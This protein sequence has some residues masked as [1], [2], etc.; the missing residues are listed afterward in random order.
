MQHGRQQRVLPGITSLAFIPAGN[1]KYAKY[2][3]S[4]S[5]PCAIATAICISSVTAAACVLPKRTHKLPECEGTTSLDYIDRGQTR[6][7]YNADCVRFNVVMNTCPYP[8]MIGWC[9]GRDEGRDRCSPQGTF[10]GPIESGAYHTIG[11]GGEFSVS[12]CQYFPERG[13]C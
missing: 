2:V 8:V 3:R 10:F 5:L 12:S 1:L 13:G 4:V 7:D 6:A 9:F 11:E